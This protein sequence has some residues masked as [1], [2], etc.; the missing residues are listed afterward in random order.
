MLRQ[1]LEKWIGIALASLVVLLAAFFIAAALGWLLGAAGD[2]L[3]QRVVRGI[4]FGLAGLILLD[5]LLMVV[6]EACLV[7]ID[8]R[9]PSE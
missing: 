8:R 4:S 9:P 3:G 7:L 1:L 5:L 6:L 2:E